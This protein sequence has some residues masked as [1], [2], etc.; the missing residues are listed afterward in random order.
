MKKVLSKMKR[1]LSLVMAFV[2]V[3]GLVPATAMAAGETKTVYLKAGVWET[4]NAWFDAWVFDSSQADAWYTFEDTD[5]DGVYSA[6]IPADATG[7]KIL[8]KDPASKEHNWNEWNNTGDL[9]IGSTYDCYEITGWGKNNVATGK[10]TTY[11][12]VAP[13][14]T[15]VGEGDLFGSNWDLDST[16]NDMTEVSSGK[17]Q[18]VFE[19]VAAGTYKYKVVRNHSWD[20]CYGD[21]SNTADN[22]NVVFTVAE[23]DSTVTITFV[24]ATKTVSH[25]VV[26]EYAVAFGDH[27]GATVTGAA[28]AEKGKSYTFNVAVN[29]G[30]ELKEDGITVAIG[31]TPVEFAYDAEAGTVTVAADKITG[32]LEITVKA[33]EKLPD[34]KTIYLKANSSFWDKDGAWFVAE[35]NGNKTQMI[36]ENLDG[37]YTVEIPY[38]ATSIKFYRMDS[39]AADASG[40]VWNKTADLTIDGN[41]YTIT[42]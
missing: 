31:G 26:K 37:V 14:Y 38:E 6:D 12:Y 18:K 27:V 25:T 22:S 7:M 36:D 3:L 15:V 17:Y 8:R 40:N 33:T 10:W 11:T 13:T 28:T 2:L 23:D 1:V 9:K 24:F 19:N 35:V 39:G 16:A 41:C 32:D 5:G 42:G 20:V 34:T 29:D 4:A 30:Y 21:P